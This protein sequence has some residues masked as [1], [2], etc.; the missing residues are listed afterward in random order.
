[1]VGN[2]GFKKGLKNV[3]VCI[4][5]GMSRVEEISGSILR[6]TKNT[7]FASGKVNFLN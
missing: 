2:E 7:D 1:M 4:G 3:V 5:I 6:F